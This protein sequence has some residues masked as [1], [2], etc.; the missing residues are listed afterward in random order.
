MVNGRCESKIRVIDIDRHTGRISERIRANRENE[1]E[2]KN[3][4]LGKDK[5]KNEEK[6]ESFI[7]KI[8]EDD[9]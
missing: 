8:N 3:N 9:I 4:T 7:F 2:K 6:K 1:I 5:K